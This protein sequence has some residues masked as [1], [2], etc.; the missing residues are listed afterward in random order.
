MEG[1]VRIDKLVDYGFR[2]KLKNVVNKL[3]SIGGNTR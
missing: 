1:E 2:K 3:E